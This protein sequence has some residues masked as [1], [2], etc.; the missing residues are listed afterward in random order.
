LFIAGQAVQ[1]LGATAMKRFVARFCVAASVSLL[2]GLAPADIYRWDNGFPGAEGIE[3]QSYGNLAH[4]NRANVDWYRADLDRAFFGTALTA[5]N[6]AE[7]R[8]SADFRFAV[9]TNAVL[10]GV[11]VTGA[12]FR[13]GTGLTK[14]Q[15]YSTAYGDVR[16]SSS[17]AA[18]K[19]LSK[20]R[21]PAASVFPL[22][23]VEDSQCPLKHP[24]IVVRRAAGAPVFR[25][26]AA[27]LSAWRVEPI[28]PPKAPLTCPK[29][30]R[31]G[32]C[33]RSTGLAPIFTSS[34]NR[35]KAT[36]FSHRSLSAP[37]WR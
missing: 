16:Q 10:A 2:A 9:L 22:L 36:F 6:F 25:S 1:A 21:A 35:R 26:Q 12:D 32:R 30:L 28:Y 23:E 14:E 11:V 19:K 34:S 18:S 37:R 15:F 31:L 8:L 3:P 29:A 20:F 4:S 33:R 27:N 5:T 7:A 17:A 24:V 13:Q